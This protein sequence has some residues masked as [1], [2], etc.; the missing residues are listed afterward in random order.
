L[1]IPVTYTKQLTDI[2]QQNINQPS[3]NESELKI[4]VILKPATGYMQNK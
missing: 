2:S 4:F 1:D 3:E